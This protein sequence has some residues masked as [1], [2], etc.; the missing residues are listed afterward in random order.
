MLDALGDV[1]YK[2]QV[3][4]WTYD[5]HADP[6]MVEAPPLPKEEVVDEL[7]DVISK[8]DVEDDG[9]EDASESGRMDQMFEDVGNSD[10]SGPFNDCTSSYK[11][12]LLMVFENATNSI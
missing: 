1:G 9:E 2:E 5:I 12:L 4:K 3:P 8:E 6:I 11:K 10:D 7:S